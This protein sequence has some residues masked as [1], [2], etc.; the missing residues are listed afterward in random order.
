MPY[1]PQ[2]A[3][4]P[5]PPGWV[6]E[7]FTYTFSPDNT[8]ALGQVPVN[9]VPLQLQPDAEYHIRGIEVS[10]NAG[11]IVIR[12]WKGG[13]QLSQTLVPVD[14]AYSGT[15]NGN[16]PVGRLPVPFEPEVLCEAGSQLLI[17][18]DVY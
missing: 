10:G 15:V 5:P 3:Y 11:N 1:R 9:Q 7:E 4:A 2:S 16:P 6:D 12:L 8:P 14:R 17:D 13:T 18:V